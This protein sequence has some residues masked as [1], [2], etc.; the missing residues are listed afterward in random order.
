MSI[1]EEEFQLNIKPITI[2][3]SLLKQKNSTIELRN[4][5]TV[6]YSSSEDI[7]ITSKIKNLL[8]Q[9]ETDKNIDFD[10]ILN[11]KIE[12]ADESNNANIEDNQDNLFSIKY[13]DIYIGGISP[14]FQKREGFGLNKYNEDQTFYVGQWKNNM[15]EGM[16]FLKIDNNIFYI[17]NFHQNQFDG[18]GILY[19]KNKNIFYIGHMSN[20]AF[21]EGVY[22]NTDNDVYYRGKF[23]NN[24]KNGDNCTMV[25]MKNR[26]IFI[27]KVENDIFEKGFLCQYN[28]EEIQ[29]GENG[30]VNF[31]IEKIFYYYKDEYNNN[32]FI[33]Q[34]ENQF[35]EV[36]KQNMQKIFEIE[37]K[38][39]G[40]I[41]SILQY[42]DYLDTLSEDLD[43]ID[44]MKYNGKG[45][46]GLLYIF[47]NNYNYYLTDYQE[48]IQNYNINEIKNEIDISQ[49][50]QRSQNE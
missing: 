22:L 45:E 38:T 48:L 31:N 1:I 40:Q 19:I 39:K 8:I 37:I 2:F 7:N 18:D 5:V 33:N 27:G 34:F 21:D 42:M 4:D 15:K 25:E 29:N 9:S 17:G 20:G 3:E 36:L 35:R 14:T 11:S 47:I 49:E 41:E 10:S 13:K 44:L 46:N 32:Q 43:F 28:A 26:H 12:N 6:T 50:I 24:I 16:G 23:V 30:E